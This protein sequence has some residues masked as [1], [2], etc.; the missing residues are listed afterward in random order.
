[1]TADG[2]EFEPYSLRYGIRIRCRTCG[3]VG[4][5][6]GDGTSPA[7]WGW[8]HIGPSA[9]TQCPVC[10]RWFVHW[11]KHASHAHGDQRALWD[12]RTDQPS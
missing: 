3:A 11:R 7:W 12:A 2:D 5:P 1:M 10:G 9:H 4:Y 6:K 8:A